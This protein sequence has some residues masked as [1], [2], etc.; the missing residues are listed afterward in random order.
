MFSERKQGSCKL[1]F[2]KVNDM[3]DLV[4]RPCDACGRAIGGGFKR[5][6]KCNIYLCFMCGL[7]LTKEF[8]EVPDVC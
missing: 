6:P 3:T 4:A 5:C 8:P 7:T 1:F 2:I